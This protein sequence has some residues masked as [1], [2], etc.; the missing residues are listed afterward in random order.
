M[1]GWAKER[2]TTPQGKRDLTSIRLLHEQ[3]L[4]RGEV[5][6]L[7]LADVDPQART[8]SVIGMGKSGR[9]PVTARE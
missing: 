4:R 5:V 8:G 7:D 3:G 1:P 6:M 2:S 9:V